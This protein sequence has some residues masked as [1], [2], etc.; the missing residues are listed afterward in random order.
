MVNNKCYRSTPRA[1][2]DGRRD[3]LP[4]LALSLLHLFRGDMSVA[5]NTARVPGRV[6]G[7]LW[8]IAICALWA[9]TPAVGQVYKCSEGGRTVF[10]DSPCPGGGG[11]AIS[12][13]PASGASAP[14]TTAGDEAPLNSSANPKAMLAKLERERKLRSVEVEIDRLEAEMEADP[15]RMNSEMAALKTKKYSAYN[16]LAGATW[17]ASISQEMQAVVQ[18]YE[19]KAV[20]DRFKLQQL[21]AQRA[22][23]VE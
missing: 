23:M 9:A 18:R 22:K 11:K 17:E 15:R 2:C 19:A 13:R 6:K 7:G 5:A 1:A 12:V 16:N 21:Q 4:M 14:A 20:S 8:A 10:S 3:R